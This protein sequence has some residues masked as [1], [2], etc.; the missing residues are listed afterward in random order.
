MKMTIDEKVNNDIYFVLQKIQ[1][2]I[3]LGDIKDNE[4]EYTL[5]VY[6]PI[7]DNPSTVDEQRIIRL[8]EEKGILTNTNQ[9]DD[10]RVGSEETNPKLTGSIFHLRI[11]LPAFEDYYEQIKNSFVGSNKHKLIITNNGRITY[12]S[13]D[14]QTYQGKLGIKTNAY[15]ALLK[16]AKEPNK[17]FTFDE[18]VADFNNPKGNS[19]DNPLP[20]RRARDAIQTIKNKLNYFGADLFKVDY[21]FGLNCSVELVK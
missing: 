13:T 7:A 9:I 17:I 18:I 14:G 19:G 12:I 11:N 20:E 16:L 5:V 21:G 3:L 8:L 6:P 10:F 2:S 15:I 4:V 1:K